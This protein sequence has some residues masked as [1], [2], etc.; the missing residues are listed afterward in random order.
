MTIPD[1]TLARKKRHPA[2]DLAFWGPPDGWESSDPPRQGIPELLMISPDLWQR[3][4]PDAASALIDLVTQACRRA[5]GP[6][7]PLIGCVV[8]EPPRPWLGGR[9]WTAALSA[10]LAA[11]LIH[12]SGD[13]VVLHASEIT[14]QGLI[15][16][17]EAEIV[18]DAVTAV[19]STKEITQP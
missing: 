5:E 12:I 6:A 14:R 18:D 19:A 11:G 1:T 2:H 13:L 3:F 17:P 10:L 9:H 15:V 8:T 4:D 16:L 7:L